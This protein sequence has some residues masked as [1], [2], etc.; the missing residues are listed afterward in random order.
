M[1]NKGDNEAK[2]FRFIM[3]ICVGLL[4]GMIVAAETA[5]AAR[6][7]LP[8]G[9]SKVMHGNLMVMVCETALR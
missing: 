4:I 8:R 7:V 2:V 1:S 3:G 9:C 6:L 5:S